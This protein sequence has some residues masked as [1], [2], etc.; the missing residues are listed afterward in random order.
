MH[1]SSVRCWPSADSACGIEPG[2][3]WKV[4]PSHAIAR[5]LDLAFAEEQSPRRIWSVHGLVEQ[6]RERVETEWADAWV[7][8]EVSNLRAAP[9][10]HL[11][12]TLK[13]AEAQLPVVLFRRQAMLLRFRPEEGVQL[14]VRGRVSVYAQRGQL[15]LV[16][17]TIEPIGAGALQLAFEQL[18]EKL[19]AEGLFDTER[20]RVLPAYPRTVAI[21]TSPSGAVIRD[22]LQVVER[23][24]AQLQVLLYPVAVQG[25]SA[26]EEIATALADLNAL[27]GIDL[28]V[29]ARG[30]GSMEDLAAFNTE[31]VAR[32][33]AASRLPVVAAIGHE[34]DF[35][36]A[37][38]VADLRAPTPSAA[39]ELVTGAL[40]GVSER[41]LEQAA[42]MERAVRYRLLRARGRLDA[43]AV[44][45]AQWRVTGLLH[46]C[47]QRLDDLT[48]R[49]DAS[50][51][52]RLR[53][54]ERQT[55]ATEAALLR[56]DPRQR[57]SFA[58]S[59]LM[60]CRDRLDRLEER[61]LRSLA[62]QLAAL[63]AQL[64]TLS[65]LAVLSR[66]Y[67]LVQNA[68]GQLVRTVTQVAAG[69]ELTTRLQ[70]GTLASRVEAVKTT[71]APG[72]RKRKSR[73][74]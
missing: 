70:D 67:A 11:Y 45:R 62:M 32:A 30:G 34:T 38:F 40:Y 33:I 59:R 52:G 60:A 61:N 19:K 66:G 73:M 12:F 6:L 37:D 71:E 49:A 57:L 24:H 13:D 55:S 21:V 65:P 41:L 22:F 44:D 47:A 72:G 35:T 74:K 23:R 8:G 5:Q 56:H 36:I 53:Q 63:D 54:L 15:Q 17:E 9:S 27:G 42:R 31:R 29:L 69:D 2:T 26:P 43:L 14:L 7:E 68:E 18:R 4:K 10:G 25:E 39:A 48:D 58:R 46:R 64:H 1:C 3:I 50:T 28:V 20:K 16:G 51:S